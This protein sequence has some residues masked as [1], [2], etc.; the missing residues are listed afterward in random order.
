M[1]KDPIT[2]GK[3]GVNEE[4]VL[5]TRDLRLVN[6]KTLQASVL[7]EMHDMPLGGHK[8]KERTLD[9]VR[10]YFWWP[11][12]SQQVAEYCR[13]CPI[14]QQMKSS[15]QKKAD[16]LNPLPIPNRRWES[17]SLDLITKLPQTKQNYGAIVV[18]VDSLS[19]MAHFI[20]T[21]TQVFAIKLAHLLFKEVWRLYK[22]PSSLV[23]DKD[24]YF[25]S[26]V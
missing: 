26:N 9:K 22:M 21:H 10:E 12:M 8:G 17:V 20:P 23:S 11:R 5:E 15:T 13:T 2:R 4:E 16:L 7:K 19:K 18:F 1:E 25:T 24:P 6:P 14:C 3:Y